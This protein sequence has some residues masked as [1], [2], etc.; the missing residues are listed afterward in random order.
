[1]PLS[2]IEQMIRQWREKQRAKQIRQN[3][4]TIRALTEDES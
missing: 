1:M 2:W 4:A 3:Q